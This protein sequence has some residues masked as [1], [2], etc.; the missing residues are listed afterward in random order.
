MIT[1]T[2]TQ[3]IAHAEADSSPRCAVSTGSAYGAES[4]PVW[5]GSF[6]FYR[7]RGPYQV[8]IH[9]WGWPAK[10][11][12]RIMS[13]RWITRGYT[14]TPEGEVIPLNTQSSATPK[15]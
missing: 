3:P 11:L 15:Q 2:E 14:P 5:R 1:A 4:S 13:P 10:L 6:D 9:I 8:R 7:D 12:W